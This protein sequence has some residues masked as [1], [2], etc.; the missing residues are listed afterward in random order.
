MR[1]L[2]IIVLLTLLQNISANP[3]AIYKKYSNAVVKI[4]LLKEE[5]IAFS[6]TGFFVGAGGVILTN[7][8]VVDGFEKKDHALRVR[9][10]DGSIYEEVAIGQCSD[11]RG[12]DLCLLKIEHKPKSYVKNS[13]KSYKIGEKVFI[14]GH[15][16]G[17]D[18][19]ISDGI[20]SGERKIAGGK[21]AKYETILT[22]KYIDS[23]QITA[24]ISSGNSGGPIFDSRG[25]LLGVAT[26]RLVN[27]E[28]QNLNF[29]VNSIEA[30][31]FYRSN[32]KAIKLTHKNRLKGIKLQ[33]PLVIVVDQVP[34]NQ[35]SLKK[36]SKQSASSKKKSITTTITQVGSIKKPVLVDPGVLFHRNQK[37]KYKGELKF[38]IPHGFGVKYN[39]IGEKV[40]EGYFK[41]GEYSGQGIKYFKGKKRYEGEFKEGKYHGIG[42]SYLQGNLIYKGGYE[43]GK[44]SGQGTKYL[45]G[46][47]YSGLYE[48]GKLDYGIK[49]DSKGIK[50]FEGQLNNYRPEGKGV[51]FSENGVFKIKASFSGGTIQ[52]VARFY[53]AKTDELIYEGELKLYMFHGKGK[54]YLDGKLIYEGDFKRSNFDGS[55]I[56]YDKSG[57]VIH[58]GLFSRGKEVKN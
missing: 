39:F 40:Y 20:L 19:T 50:R 10:H 37:V 31:S 18:W 13:R 30:L 42:K 29:G 33:T 11:D 5:K 14:I 15:P 2:A 51:Y 9:L 4:E 52:G 41:N 53:L 8:H 25:K 27:K 36:E 16:H 24:P 43:G 1:L 46:N 6:G 23:I 21:I 54:Y 47:S 28:A 12:L 48:N 56:L 3:R 34:K 22:E 55:G 49:Y 38:D 32:H 7:Y 45:V 35:R 44:E 17:L 58:K 26:W 57:E